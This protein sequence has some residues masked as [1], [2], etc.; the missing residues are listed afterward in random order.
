MDHPS[1]TFVHFVKKTMCFHTFLVSEATNL[2]QPPANSSTQQPAANGLDP[3]VGG[4][5]GS[6]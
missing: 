5:G 4:S 6:Q 3:G 1:H 2:H